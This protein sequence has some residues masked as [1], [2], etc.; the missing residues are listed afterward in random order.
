M[1]RCGF[2]FDV[3]MLLLNAKV[4]KEIVIIIFLME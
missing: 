2:I 3:N 1:L 4:Q